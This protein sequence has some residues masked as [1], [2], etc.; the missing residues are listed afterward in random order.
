MGKRKIITI[1][2][3]FGSGGHEIGIKLAARL[4]I[5]CY[6]NELLSEAAKDSGISEEILKKLDEKPTN[7]FL[8][9]LVMDSYVGFNGIGG[10][11]IPLSQ[12]VFMA[13][14]E[15]I[16]KIAAEE[17]CVFVG[18][19]ADYT[20]QD[21]YDILSVFIHAQFEDRVK[22]IS[23]RLV[24]PEN[25]AKDLIIHTDKKRSNYYNYYTNKK[26]S[27]SSSYDLCINSSKFSFDDC[28]N[29]IIDALEK[30]K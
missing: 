2:R 4:N 30:R 7:S 5:N 27:D 19:C 18:R 1:G 6:D 12:R 28:V 29:I 20:L 13:Q 23:N 14:F 17:D 3:Q 22:R 25:K 16:K 9:S 8:Y 24:L 21:E 26:W 10:Y 15:A 11:E